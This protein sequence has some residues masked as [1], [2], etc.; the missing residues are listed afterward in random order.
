MSLVDRKIYEYTRR[1]GEELEPE[2]SATASLIRLRD[3]QLSGNKRLINLLEKERAESLRLPFFLP[4]GKVSLV[5]RLLETGKTPERE[6][7]FRRFYRRR[8]TIKYPRM[9]KLFLC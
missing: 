3:R 5:G 2:N 9:I 6:P 7:A 8:K 1:K 4:F